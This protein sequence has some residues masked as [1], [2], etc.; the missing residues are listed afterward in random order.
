[1]FTKDVKK[2]NDDFDKHKSV[3][4]ENLT[5]IFSGMENLKHL[6][7]RTEIPFDAVNAAFRLESAEVYCVF[8]FIESS[9]STLKQIKVFYLDGFN[10]YKLKMQDLQ[11]FYSKYERL[12]DLS[13]V[14][15]L[16]KEDL[17]KP[18]ESSENMKHLNVHIIDKDNSDER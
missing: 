10:G 17:Q 12:E 1:M 7:M 14:F 13:A 2:A 4:S 3:V 8:P 5:S 18:L 9:A 6:S 15:H 16:T 11:D